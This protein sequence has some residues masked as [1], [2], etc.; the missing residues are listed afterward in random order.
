MLGKLTNSRTDGEIAPEFSRIS[1]CVL[2]SD[3][4]EAGKI[5]DGLMKDT[6]RDG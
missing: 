5:I 3:F 2:I 1:D 6:R 4:D